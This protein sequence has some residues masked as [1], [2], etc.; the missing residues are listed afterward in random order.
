[1]FPGVSHLIASMN[2][3]SFDAITIK[4]QMI[5]NIGA[6]CINSIADA[7]KKATHV[8]AVGEVTFLHLTIKLMICICHTPKE[9]MPLPCEKHLLLHDIKAENTFIFNEGDFE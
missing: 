2:H 4:E 3:S 6:M 9:R 7:H 1:M 5:Q 8:I